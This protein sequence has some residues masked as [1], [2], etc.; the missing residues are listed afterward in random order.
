MKVYVADGY[1]NFRKLLVTVL[2]HE[3]HEV[4]ATH[5]GGE[6]LAMIVEARPDVAVADLR[7]AS[8]SALDVL[9]E[10]RQAGL[11]VPV[12]VMTTEPPDEIEQAVAGLGPVR[13][14][15]KPF[16]LDAL[17]AAFTELRATR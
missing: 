1:A 10:L 3:G 4:S 12:V 8:Q 17:Q 9:L 15:Q 5:D 6:L 7:L 16:T 13:V 2:E 14:L 11:L